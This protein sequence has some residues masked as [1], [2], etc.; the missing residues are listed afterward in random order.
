MQDLVSWN[1]NGIRALQK[2][3][4]LDWLEESAPDILCVQETKA[5]PEQLGEA[6]L[7]PAGYRS[8]WFSAERKGYSGVAA[9]VRREPEDMAPLGTPEFDR[10]GRTMILRYP[11]FTLFNCYF[12]NSQPEGARL[13]YKLAYCDA[14][15][16]ACRERVARGENVIVCGDFNIA[17]KP[18]D[19]ARPKANEKNPGYLPEER[20]WMDRFLGGGYVDAFRMFCSEPGRYTWWS[21]RARARAKNIGWRIDYHCVNEGFRGQIRAAEILDR[22]TGSDHCPVR[23]LVE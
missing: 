5:R 21:Y 20:A 13:E 18:I 16:E 10:E 22:V 2:K 6:L 1:V 17:H 8:L 4:F 19:L 23:L 11:E 14:V 7:E 12:P 15:F 3:G 9:F